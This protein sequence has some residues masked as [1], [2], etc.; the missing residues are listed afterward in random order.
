MPIPSS[1]L[2]KINTNNKISSQINLARALG[3][4]I[5]ELKQ[6][7]DLSEEKKYVTFPLKKIDGSERLIHKPCKE[8]RNIQRR[9]NHRIF[10]P[11]IVWPEYLYGSIPTEK[12]G[13]VHD[14]VNCAKK[15]CLSKSTLKLD[16]KDFFDNIDEALVKKIFKDFFKYNDSVSDIL[17]KICCTN[18]HVPQGA[19]T[20]SYIASLCL[21]S[22][23]PLLAQRLNNKKLK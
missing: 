5:K 21:Y 11:L 10:K 22:I 20:S 13:V 7:A 23:E 19:L 12:G 17:T 3:V 18:G 4:S 1:Y 14:Y 8:I 16:I 15:H 2:F 9:I 6:I